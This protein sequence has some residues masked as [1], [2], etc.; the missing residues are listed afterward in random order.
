MKLK[1][2]ISECDCEKCSLMCHA[3]CCGT[4]EDMEALMDAGY[5]NRL[6]YDDWPDGEKLLKP[7]LKGYEGQMAPW[8]TRSEEGCTFWKDGKCELHSLGLKPAQ[9]KLTIHNQS[10]EEI[11]EVCD[12][13]E[14]SW[15]KKKAVKTIER[16]KK[17]NE[18]CNI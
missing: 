15:R 3:P 11:E 2:A 10:E 6:M 18:G 4:V 5:G 1:V 8:E 17:I 16:W 13:L 7:S 12:Y 14:D 9:G